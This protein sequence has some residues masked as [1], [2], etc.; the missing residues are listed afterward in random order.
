MKIKHVRPYFVTNFVKP[1]NTE[2]KHI[3]GKWYLYERTTRYNPE[4]GKS[5]KVS[6]KM[7]GSITEQG[8]M[9][10]KIA[11]SHV[12]EIEVVELGASQYFYEKGALIRERLK[13]F[14]PDVCLQQQ[15]E[16]I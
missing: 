5:T 7:L 4:T 8:F 6:G 9:A 12:L 1:K 10:R 2:I 14:F 11:F 16:D 15:L 13:E 3:S